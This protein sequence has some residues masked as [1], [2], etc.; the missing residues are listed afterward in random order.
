MERRRARCV[1]HEDGG[2][3]RARPELANAKVFTPHDDL[4]RE[5]VRRIAARRDL[6]AAQA[7]SRSG[8]AQRI[9]ESKSCARAQFAGARPGRP[10]ATRRAAGLSTLALRPCAAPL[11][12]ERGELCQRIG[13]DRRADRIEDEFLR[14]VQRAE[15]VLAGGVL[16]VRLLLIF[17]ALVIP[18]GCVRRRGFG[19]WRA[20]RFRHAACAGREHEAGGNSGVFLAGLHAPFKRGVD[21]RGMNGRQ[22]GPDRVGADR[23]GR[24]HERL[25]E[26]IGNND[27]TEAFASSFNIL[28]RKTLGIL[29][30]RVVARHDE[31]E[32]ILQGR[33]DS[34]L[35]HALIERNHAKARLRGDAHAVALRLDRLHVDCC[36][37]TR[38]GF[39]RNALGHRQ[40]ERAA[41]G[42]RQNAAAGHSAPCGQCCRKIQSA[43][44]AIVGDGGGRAAH[45]RVVLKQIEDRAQEVFARRARR[46]AHKDAAEPCG[47]DRE[48]GCGAREVHSPNRLASARCT[49]TPESTSSRT[50]R[51]SR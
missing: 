19:L 3:E 30:A 50:L 22:C 11:L 37:D 47:I 48:K 28:P 33:V 17:A 45:G 4:R 14:V 20:F 25:Y 31:G 2:D 39:S 35:V 9:E 23:K 44:K 26:R 1:H 36:A 46:T 16:F 13:R 6:L 7:L 29:R 24:R 49:R 12:H 5:R 43:E 38:D 40:D 27:S 15:V 18:V 41:V 21:A 51:R 32:T 10:A 8:R 42:F 34:F